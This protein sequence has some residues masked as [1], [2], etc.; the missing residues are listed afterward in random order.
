MKN[1]LK[2]AHGLVTKKLISQYKTLPCIQE[3]LPVVSSPPEYPVCKE[4]LDFLIDLL[5]QLEI[6]YIFAHADE[7]VYA[8]LCHIL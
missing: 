8:K 1:L 4:Y 5:R 3:Y 2:L 6:P 7:M